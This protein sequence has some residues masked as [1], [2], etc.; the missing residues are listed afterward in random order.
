MLLPSL[1]AFP[2]SISMFF[3]YIQSLYS[4]I[5]DSHIFPHSELS[6]ATY[7]STYL[8]LPTNIYLLLSTY[9]H[10][11]LFSFRFSSSPGPNSKFL[12]LT[13]TLLPKNP[14]ICFKALRSGSSLVRANF[15]PPRHIFSVPF[16]L[17]ASPQ[18][19]RRQP[20]SRI[21]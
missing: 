8:H 16:C 13:C 21:L 7:L 15:S 6:P 1:L 18:T 19:G 11:P 5:Q 9:L 17:M 10:L 12:T 14:Y 3:L 4:P 20:F 2:L